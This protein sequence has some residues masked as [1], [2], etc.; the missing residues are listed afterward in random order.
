ML[1]DYVGIPFVPY[2]RTL[3]GCD[4][5]GLVRLYLN[6]ELGV[7]LPSFDL[8]YR[9]DNTAEI[10]R[11]INAQAALLCGA[12]IVTPSI[13][14]IAIMRYAGEQ[15][16]LG[17]YVGNGDILHTT[18]ESGSHIARSTDLRIRN[19]IVEYINVN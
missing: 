8:D 15:I 19:R 5:Y 13:G 6:N 18:P 9:L 4:C 3:K 11:L 17:V 2:G 14:S 16:H 12:P 7:L 10:E 1:G